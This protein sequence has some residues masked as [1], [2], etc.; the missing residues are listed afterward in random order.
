MA[1]RPITQC[2]LVS[3]AMNACKCGGGGVAGGGGW[4]WLVAAKMGSMM[5]NL[6]FFWGG[7]GGQYCVYLACV[8]GRGPQKQGSLAERSTVLQRSQ[9]EGGGCL[10]KTDSS[11]LN[12]QV[13]ESIRRR[14][15]TDRR[16]VVMTDK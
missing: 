15:G 6:C 2:S 5:V 1:N 14:R 8:R 7:G 3:P 13:R 9:A 10:R 16:V 11:V 12:L 4:L